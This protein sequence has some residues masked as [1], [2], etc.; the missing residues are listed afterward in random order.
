[1]MADF[2]LLFIFLGLALFLVFIFPLAILILSWRDYR[3]A[4]GRFQFSLLE[5]AAVPLLAGY[6]VLMMQQ[7]EQLVGIGRYF[8]WPW[9][10]ALADLFVTGGMTAWLMSGQP[11]Y[12]SRKN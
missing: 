11:Q 6:F 10:A 5:L 2:D 1:M 3:R 8:A 7:V 9:R 12:S 4:G